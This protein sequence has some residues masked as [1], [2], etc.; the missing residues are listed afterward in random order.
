MADKKISELPLL[1]AVSGSTIIVPIVHDG[2]T[3]KLNLSQ[4][5]QYSSQ[6][7]AKTGSANTFTGNQTVNGNLILNGN[8]VI[9]GNVEVGGMITAQQY[10]VTYVSSSIQYQSG[11]T[12]FGDTADDTHTFTGTLILNGLAI[13]TAQLMA[14]TASQNAINTGISA[15]T[16]AFA[17]QLGSIDSHILAQA[18]QTGSQDLVNFRISSVT[19]SINTTTSSFNSV[20]LGI[21]S[22][23]GAMN[24]QSSS[25]NL[26]NL[27]ISSV[28]GSLIGITNGL[29]AFTQSV[30]TISGSYATTGSNNFIGNQRITGSLSIAGGQFNVL[31]GSGQLTSSL[32]FTHNITA[33]N[34]GNAILE[35]RH[36]NDLYNDD[37]AIKLKADFAGAYIDYEEDGTPYSILSVQSFAN[38]NV[39]IHQDTRLLFSNLTVDDNLIVKQN[40]QL[41]G[42]LIVVGGIT[43]SLLSTNGVV[44]SSNQLFELNQQT[45]SQNSV[46]LG[47]STA[48]G[49][50]IGITNGLMAFT[51]AL[52]NTYATDAQLY[53]L[54]QSTRSLE[55][56]S[57][58]MIGV[59]NGL[60][61]YTASNST[62]NTGLRGEVDGIEAYTASLK[63]QAIVSSS[64]QITNYY[65]FAETASAN[66]NFYGGLTVT[67]Y[68]KFGKSGV[69]KALDVF[70]NIAVTGSVLTQQNTIGGFVG[71]YYLQWDSFGSQGGDAQASVGYYVGA[72]NDDRKLRITSDTDIQLN[73]GN[74]IGRKIQIPRTGIG[75]G[76]V[77]ELTGSFNVTGSSTTVG[78]LL[79]TLGGITGSILATNGVLS[80]SAQIGE[81]TQIAGIEAYTASLK[82]AAIVSSSTQIENYFLFAE[83]SSANTFYGDQTISGSLRVN[84]P[85]RGNIISGGLDVNGGITGS[86]KGNLDGV[87]AYASLLAVSSAGTTTDT[88]LYPTFTLSPI[89]G[90]YSG[91]YSH[92]S[93]SFFLNGVTRRVHM[94][95]FVV[96]GSNNIAEISGSLN[97]SGSITINSGSI[98]MPNR[99]AFRVVG[100]GSTDRV[101]QTTLSGS[102][103]SIDYNEGNYYNN[104]TGIF[105]APLTG[106]YNVYYNGRCGSVNAQQQV[107]IY[108]NGET[109]TPQLMW[110]APGNTGVAHFGVSGVFKLVAGDTLE[111]KVAVGSIQFDGNDTW[112]V[113]YIG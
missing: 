22:V 112:G 67:D 30:N 79:V 59:T 15:V 49:S 104:S 11:S 37:I 42:S 103:A 17:I 4:L 48:T 62:L 88:T 113:A 16:G 53:Q 51:A 97:V 23:T 45:G 27:G 82:A 90:S 85:I 106:L 34:D 55:L 54:Y 91:L 65:K 70:G 102:Y 109:G 99:P 73:H 86:F 39:Y 71:S 92:L 94:E 110:E 25:Q 12:E 29:M 80:G 105:T 40:T 111:A 6:W 75:L 74:G 101:A 60:M 50:L 95:G 26:V 96:S 58:S 61:A 57:G 8:G 19:G 2:T 41:T 69:A 10:N 98:A 84:G 47:I 24:T 32:T 28:T 18:I 46:N 78:D 77:V 38:K 21:S 52:D 68:S 56:H 107:I 31:T 108:K 89:V 33:P 100:T 9:S 87:A 20:F 7:S 43:G 63:G 83:T 66:T 5:A 93:G 64:Q 36:N 3:A 81:L 1:N 76:S 35:L 72:S 44:S 13:G 14:Q